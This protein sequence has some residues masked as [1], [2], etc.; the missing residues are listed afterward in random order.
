MLPNI[1]DILTCL[2]MNIQIL[3]DQRGYEWNISLFLPYHFH[4]LSPQSHESDHQFMLLLLT[5][6]FNIMM[7]FFLARRVS[8]SI[9]S[10]LC[11]Q[12]LCL[13]ERN[14]IFLYQVETVSIFRRNQYGQRVVLPLQAFRSKVSWVFQL[15][16]KLLNKL[17]PLWISLH[18]PHCLLFLS[19]VAKA[20]YMCNLVLLVA[21]YQFLKYHVCI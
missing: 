14:Y 9:L 3:K 11:T 13:N 16:T 18:L 6:F 4:V 19:E 5:F 17:I 2:V 15:V 8:Y 1:N 10:H 20:K 7:T 21:V 12:D